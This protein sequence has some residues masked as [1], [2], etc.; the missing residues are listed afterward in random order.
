MIGNIK[1]TIV[2]QR[3]YNEY[4]LKKN[5]VV[6]LEGGS[7]SSKTVSLAQLFVL[8]MMNEVDCQITVAR[9]TLPSLRA[10]AMKDVLNEINKLGIYH[11]EWH[12]KSDHIF[13]YAPTRSVIEFISVDEPKKVRSRRRNYLWMNETNEFDLEDY[14]QLAMR[15]DTQI[16]MDYNPSD[17]FHWIYDNVQTREDCLTIPSTYKDNPFLSNEIVKEIEAY[18]DKDPNYWRVYGLG[19]RG[20]KQTIIYKHWKYCDKLPD[21]FDIKIFGLDFGYN[22]QTA[23]VEIRE[24]DK[25][26]YWQERLY[27]RFLTNTDLC[28][29]EES[30]K[31]E[32][33]E[34]G[35]LHQLVKD[36]VLT[37]DDEVY[38]D[39]AEPD[40]IKE[41]K[42]AGFNIIPCFKGKIKDRIDFVKSHG[43]Y[44]T[45]DSVSL[46]KEV[47]S[48]SWKEK[49]GIVKEDEPVKVNDHLMDAGG[50]A[51]ITFDKKVIPGLTVF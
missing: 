10:T 50:Y 31:I 8:I 32:G 42:D 1:S 22:N 11:K 14:R 3:A 25:D 45:K 26:Y 21:N 23:L 51:I 2:F 4:L 19:L 39:N 7:G 12:N 30:A 13:T 17:Q 43:F 47:K 5:R 9:K 28:R 16:F 37:Y 44:I 18:K 29:S 24:K 46:L 41:I 15:T 38:A 35:R 20:V 34:I 49:D 6:V 40:R 27:E 33:K 36:G 48:Y